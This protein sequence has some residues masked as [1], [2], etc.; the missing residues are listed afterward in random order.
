MSTIA[1]VLYRAIPH[2]KFETKSLELAYKKALRGFLNDADESG[3]VPNPETTTEDPFIYLEAVIDD[4]ENIEEDEIH[5][6]GNAE[7]TIKDENAEEVWPDE[8][9]ES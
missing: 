2:I 9:I 4:L 7:S 5:V 8:D 6:N 3:Y 1:D